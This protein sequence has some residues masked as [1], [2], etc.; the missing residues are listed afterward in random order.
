MNPREVA[1][2]LD[3][4]ATLGE[5][6]GD[7]PFRSRAFAAAARA[8]E[9]ST[10]DLPAL[11]G[12]GELTTLDGVGPGI[13][14]VIDELVRTGRSRTHEELRARTPPG[15]YDVLRIPGLG[16]RRVRTLHTDLGI[17]GLDALEAAGREGRIAAL[18]GF[19]ARTEQKILG[20]IA[21]VR[22]TRGRRRY[23]DALG[24]AV[25][26]LER[27]R[28]IDGVSAVEIAGA[29]RRRCE[30]VNGVQLVAAADDPGEVLREFSRIFGGAEAAEASDDGVA[31]RIGGEFSVHLRCVTPERFVAACAWETGSETH[32]REL[33]ARAAERGLRLDRDGLWRGD[34]PI[35]LPQESALYAALGLPYV[36]PELREGMGEVAAAAAGVLPHLVELPDLRGTFH[37]HTTYSD[38]KATV[39][40]MA[41]AARARGWSYL[42]LADHSPSAGYAGGVSPA[43][44]REQHREIDA[45]NAEHGGAGEGRFR[46]FRGTESDILPDG[47]LDYPDEVLATFDYVVGSVHSSFGLPEK[48]MTER[49]I[50]AIRNPFLTVLGHPTGRLLLGRDAYAI[51]VEATIDAAAENGVA[52]E[53]NADPHRLDLDWRYLRYA[54]ERGVVIPI[55]PDA[56][57]VAGLDNVAFGVNAARKGWLEAPTVLNT[58][59]L[60]EIEKYFASRKQNR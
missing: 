9:S 44:L 33:R 32:L 42:G 2:V 27:V 6:N 37:C 18:S 19:G 28:E 3:E 57:S 41:E 14:E 16:T 38:G 29:L 1:R 12:T 56:H 5:L 34:E 36:A 50:R 21:F 10:A 52:I 8:L 25:P 54:A 46:V 58:W 48:K 49:V 24:A 35:P 59:T 11:A 55:N 7:N 20:G 23:P 17:D 13:A 26:I 39:A 4:I 30:V 15:L 51:D 31:L 40:E 43:R 47:S 60:D 53:I 22:A 45:W